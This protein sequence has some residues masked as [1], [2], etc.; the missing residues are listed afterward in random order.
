MLRRAVYFGRRQLGIEEPFV[1][2]MVDT[3]SGAMSASYPEL[4]RTR[5]FVKEIVGPEEQRFDATLSRGLEMLE[6][7]IGKKGARKEL[8][9]ADAVLLHDTCGC[10]TDVTSAVAAAQGLIRAEAGFE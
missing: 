3:V 8:S 5:G 9:G 6:S 10:R 4:E 2:E 7:L 1:A